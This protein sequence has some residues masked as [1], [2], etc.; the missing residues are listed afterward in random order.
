MES[1]K[2]ISIIGSGNVAFHLCK[3]FSEV[4]DVH[5]IE[6]L[7]R[8]EITG[9]A[10]AKK[11]NL[12]Q[13]RNPKALTGDLVLICTKDDSILELTGQI[14]EGQ[15]VAYTSGSLELSSLNR[16]DQTGVFY[17]L[18]TFTKN[19]NVNYFEI[20]FL[21]EATD[22]IFAQELFDLAWKMSHLVTF[23]NST[24]RKKYHYAAVWVNNFTNHMVYQAE[25]YLHSEDLNPDFL[26]P[27]LQETIEKLKIMPAYDAQT[28]PARRNDFSTIERHIK[29]SDEVTSTLYNAISQSIIKSYPPHD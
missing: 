9:A 19:K 21:I 14:T 3:A 26:K 11:Y 6:V 12:T 15:K 16:D 28:G 8:N 23:A 4:E 20:P 17:P 5:V 10:L 25:K 18:Q 7:S 22:T 24:I 29:M 27:L 2:T 13:I 1:I